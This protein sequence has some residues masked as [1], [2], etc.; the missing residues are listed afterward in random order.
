MPG[1]SSSPRAKLV[2][3]TDLPRDILVKLTPN[4]DRAFTELYKHREKL[5]IAGLSRAAVA[6]AGTAAEVAAAIAELRESARI[7][8]EHW[9]P[10]GTGRQH[11]TYS[12]LRSIQDAVEAQ[13]DPADRTTAPAGTRAEQ[14]TDAEL[15]AAAEAKARVRGLVSATYTVKY[16]TPAGVLVTRAATWPLT[17]D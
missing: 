3:T 14:M 7:E 13:I 6:F 10:R 15:I 12:G 5:P 8:A 9:R 16:R 2:Y 11:Q 17:T 1:P 4:Q